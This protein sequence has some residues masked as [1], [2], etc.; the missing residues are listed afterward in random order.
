VGI[1][2]LVSY[3]CYHLGVIQELRECLG[4]EG[5]HANADERLKKGEKPKTPNRPDKGG[6]QLNETNT[7]VISWTPPIVSASIFTML[8]FYS[9][10]VT[11]TIENLSQ[12]P[13]FSLWPAFTK[14]QTKQ[15]NLFPAEVFL[16]YNLLLAMLHLKTNKPTL[17]KVR[18]TY[19]SQSS[20]PM[21][22]KSCRVFLSTFPIFSWTW[23]M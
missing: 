8:W 7:Y 15:T 4:G 12:T 18:I 1:I 14:E 11:A 9:A 23:L 22:N 21:Q 6:G 5:G 20:T 19:V 3:S 13:I 2:F 10:N 17:K 16:R